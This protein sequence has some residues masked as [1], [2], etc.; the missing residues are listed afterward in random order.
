MKKT[1][2]FLC[3]IAFAIYLGSCSSGTN[4]KTENNPA[5]EK[6]VSI[7]TSMKGLTGVIEKNPPVMNGDYVSKYPNGIIK[8]KGF[9]INGKRE[10]QW[11]SFFGNGEKQS[12]GFFKNG[13]RDG[14]AL[15]Y[16]ENG[17]VYYEGFYRNGKTVGKL[18]FYDM[19][20]KKIKEKDYGN[21]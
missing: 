5:T 11:T 17:Q 7:D 6:P 12:E 21:P 19:Q 3:L 14:R 1:F 18:I 16:Y 9:Y 2:L 15:V 8:M 20:G 4:E 13:L 10:G